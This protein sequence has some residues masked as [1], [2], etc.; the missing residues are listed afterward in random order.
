MAQMSKE[1]GEAI[2][3]LAAECQA[4]EEYGAALDTVLSVFNDNPEYMDFLA[5]PSIPKAERIEALEKAFGNGLPEH[6]VSFVSLLCE[7]G[8]IREFGDCVKGYRELLDASKHIGTAKVTSATELTAAEKEKLQ[9]KL[10]K[11]S[12]QTVIPE[13]CI[14]ESLLGGVIIEMDGRVM[15]GSVRR[16]LYEVKEV[17]SG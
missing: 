11:I 13:Y 3:M 6:I 5:S 1:Y 8:R 16:R 10:E 17:I 15:D 12:G 4:A 9:K 14:D 7:R 2:Y